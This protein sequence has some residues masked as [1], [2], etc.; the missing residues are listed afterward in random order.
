MAGS[1]DRRRFLSGLAPALG[2]LSIGTLTKATPSTDTSA[3]VKGK[4]SLAYLSPLNQLH[5][6]SEDELAWVGDKA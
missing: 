5:V 2:L 1:M 3:F 4:V 6:Y